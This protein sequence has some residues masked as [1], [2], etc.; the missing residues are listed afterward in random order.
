[1]PCASRQMQESQGARELL[2][3]EF[4]KQPTGWIMAGWTISSISHQSCSCSNLSTSLVTRWMTKQRG[5]DTRERRTRWRP[6]GLANVTTQARS[7]AHIDGAVGQINNTDNC[8]NATSARHCTFCCVWFHETPRLSK[9]G[10]NN[11]K[12]QSQNKRSL[13]TVVAM[14]LTLN[15]INACSQ[16][17]LCLHTYGIVGNFLN[18]PRKCFLACNLATNRKQNTTLMYKETCRRKARHF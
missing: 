10:Q 18:Y 11:I 14:T 4:S 7:D 2:D 16:V 5:P 15:G 6:N 3:F 8:D 17:E 9:L 12:P 13:Q 1:M